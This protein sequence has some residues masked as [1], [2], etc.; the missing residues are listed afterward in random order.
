MSS[1]H[2]AET[3]AA[4]PPRCPSS[5]GLPNRG[6]GPPSGSS[7]AGG[8]LRNR[9][10]LLTGTKQV[11]RQM[12]SRRSWKRGF[13]FSSEGGAVAVELRGTLQ[14]GAAVPLRG[15]NPRRDELTVA[16]KARQTKNCEA[17]A[18]PCESKGFVA[19]LCAH[20][21]ISHYLASTG[22]CVAGGAAAR[23][24]SAAGRSCSSRGA[25]RRRLRAAPPAPAHTRRRQQLHR[26]WRR[27]RWRWRQRRRRWNQGQQQW[28]R[29][30][31]F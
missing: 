19:S 15:A 20:I 31:W 11:R 1:A 27:W 14:A 16:K 29:W 17:P 2:A 8:L 28:W 22:V 3:G 30:R 9:L 12:V 10:G 4:P 6:L 25:S 23:A 26:K 18:S 13:R 21:R 24:A 7:G 5:A